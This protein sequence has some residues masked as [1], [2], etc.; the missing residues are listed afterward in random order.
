MVLYEYGSLPVRL[1]VVRQEG[2]VLH[3]YPSGRVRVVTVGETGQAATTMS[4]K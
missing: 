1:G 2:S 4:A 3:L